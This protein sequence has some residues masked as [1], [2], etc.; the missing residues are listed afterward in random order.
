MITT[1]NQ[2]ATH[3]FGYSSEEAIGKSI[4]MLIPANLVDEEVE[5]IE[6][7]R[8]GQRV[9]HYETRRKR[10]DGSLVDVSLTIS[11][12]ISE[13]GEVVGASKIARDITQRKRIEEANAKAAQELA[14][15]H[16]EFEMRV[17]ERTASLKEAVAQMEEFSYTISHDLRAPLRA[18]NFRCSVLLEDFNTL[19]NSE[20]EVFSNLKSIAE[21]CSKLDRM[22]RDVLTY[23]KITREKLTLSPISL[24]QLI[25]ET[26]ANYPALQPPSA[27]I[28]IEP[29]GVVIAHD[30]FL[31]QVVSNLLSNAIK[32]VDLGKTPVVHIWSEVLD[33]NIRLWIEDNG[34]GIEP[35][36]Q[37]RLFSIF[38]RIH[39][40]LPYEGTGVGLAVVKRAAE[41]MGGQVGVISDGRNG[42]K[43]WLDLPK[44]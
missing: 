12:I 25:Q 40:N 10:K 42:S 4:T 26:V 29:L 41:R 33:R 35:A 36:Y 15:S 44:A 31:T 17:Q 19:L 3:I 22:I 30:T 16:E 21:N 13:S 2:G 34:I 6:R 43:F 32:F 9:E 37:H 8:A 23:G 39:P 28:R 18:I 5:I 20:P 14:R 11:P 1:W 24:D 27:L 38:E 7:I